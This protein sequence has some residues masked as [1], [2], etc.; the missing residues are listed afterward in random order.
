MLKN[1]VFFGIALTFLVGCNTKF[2]INGEYEEKPIVHFLLDQGQ[3]YQFL[4][5]N[6]TFLKE[7]DALE[8]AKD[9]ELS[10]FD[11]VD[12]VVE[13]VVGGN[14]IRS[15]TLTDTLINNK[16]EGA[17]YGPDQ[18]LYYFKATDLDAQATYR[19]KIDIDNGNHMITGQTQ[20]VQGVSIKL[21]LE[22]QA[23]NFADNDVQANGY[24]ETPIT[25][26][27]GDGVIFNM[28]LRFDYVEYTSSTDS[29]HHSL[30]WSLGTL[31][32]MDIGGTTASLSADGELFYQFLKAK[33]PV[34]PNVI[35]RSVR[36]MDILLTAGSNDLNTYILSSSP[37]TSLAQNKPVFTNV[38]GAL[39]IFSARVTASQYKPYYMQVNRRCLN[40]KSTK[41]LCTGQYTTPLKFC[42]DVPLDF[43]KSYACD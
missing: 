42:S 20:L 23:F 6:R 8:Y 41:E 25:F 7:G 5:L 37:S 3:E 40:Q 1:I 27:V 32:G 39:G 14:V 11:Q 22:G 2:N 21:P 15:W 24:K 36:G 30:L 16:K 38:S 29:S 33:I 10:Y 18:K 31:K 19:L 12:A 35:R 34:D 28:K 26:N 43:S 4:K 13:E 17:F 9:A